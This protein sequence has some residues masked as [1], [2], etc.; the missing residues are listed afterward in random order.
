M[1]DLAIL[2]LTDRS[3]ATSGATSAAAQF[4]IL[5]TALGNTL[6]VTG[7]LLPPQLCKWNADAPAVTWGNWVETISHLVSS[8]CPRKNDLAGHI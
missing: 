1:G 5:A 4:T 6:C 8:R 7:K 2:A 3:G